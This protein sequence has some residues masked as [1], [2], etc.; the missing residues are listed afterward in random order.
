MSIQRNENKKVVW[1]GV[2]KRKG[3]TH[4]PITLASL[5]SG[6]VKERSPT[7]FT[8]TSRDFNCLY[9]VPSGAREASACAH[10]VQNTGVQPHHIFP[11]LVSCLPGHGH[12]SR[13]E[14]ATDRRGNCAQLCGLINA[15]RLETVHIP[16]LAPHQPL[17]RTRP[18]AAQFSSRRA[19]LQ[20]PV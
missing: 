16:V 15:L 13:S 12:T 4:L 1:C 10:C 7:T 17:A 11:S 19:P 6:R 18:A 8:C 2:V 9:A 5:P 14:C 3:K 20:V